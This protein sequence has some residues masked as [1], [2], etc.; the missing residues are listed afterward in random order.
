MEIKFNGIQATIT[1][2]IDHHHDLCTKIKRALSKLPERIKKDTETSDEA[3][4]VDVA[5]ISFVE[6]ATRNETTIN[7]AGTRES[8]LKTLSAVQ[9]KAFGDAQ[10]DTLFSMYDNFV[11]SAICLQEVTYTSDV[12]EKESEDLKIIADAYIRQLK[13]KV[14]ELDYIAEKQRLLGYSD[15]GVGLYFRDGSIGYTSNSIRD[16]FMVIRRIGCFGQFKYAVADVNSLGQIGSGDYYDEH[17]LSGLF[18]AVRK[19][20][21]YYF[22]NSMRMRFL[23]GSITPRASFLKRIGDWIGEP[24]LLFI[25]VKKT[26]KT[27]LK[28]EECHIDDFLFPDG[29]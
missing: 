28:A 12:F 13:F 22:R 6:N 1:L 29:K 17:D 15:A 14:L 7:I 5:N 26:E 23:E 2:T 24:P 4:K 8:V 11:L 16:V 19:K 10:V 27:E 20:I 21:F 25:S 3:E 9:S 18:N